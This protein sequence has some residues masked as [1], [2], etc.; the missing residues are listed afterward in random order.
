[1]TDN[2]SKFFRINPADGI[3]RKAFLKAHGVSKADLVAIAAGLIGE[4][5]WLND[6]RT[7]NGFLKS[8]VAAA[9]S[10][11]EK[12]VNAHAETKGYL[13]DVAA[14]LSDKNEGLKLT[15]MHRDLAYDESEKALAKLDKVIRDLEYE[16]EA[17][18]ITRDNARN[19]VSQVVHMYAPQTDP[20]PVSKATLGFTPPSA[21]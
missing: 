7:D 5:V 11:F 9:E 17:H 15:V 8:D 19:L 13:R 20:Q 21:K 4:N 18:Q 2:S 1:M 12:E 3:M 16:R 6:L 14:E 10:N